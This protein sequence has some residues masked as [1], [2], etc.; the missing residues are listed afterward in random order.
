MRTQK[1]EAARAL[2]MLNEQNEQS[3][4]MTD[5]TE[6]DEFSRARQIWTLHLLMPWRLNYNSLEVKT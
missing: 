5:S 6:V 2:V 1:S 3:A 4:G